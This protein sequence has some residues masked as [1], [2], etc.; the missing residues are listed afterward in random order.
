MNF[1]KEVKSACSFQSFVPR[2]KT[3]TIES[4]SV[5]SLSISCLFILCI[6]Y[7]YIYIYRE[8]E[9]EREREG[10]QENKNVLKPHPIKKKLTFS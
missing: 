5:L 7:I 2:Y 6:R 1:I 10:F 3:I 8:R 4:L 9:R